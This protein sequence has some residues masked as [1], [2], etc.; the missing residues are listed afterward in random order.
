MNGEIL[1]TIENRVRKVNFDA[2]WLKNSKKFFQKSVK[3]WLQ[4]AFYN[5]KYF[6]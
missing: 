1:S 3:N 6:L 4:T 2:S 5:E